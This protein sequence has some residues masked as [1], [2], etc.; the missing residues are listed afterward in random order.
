MIDDGEDRKLVYLSGT[1]CEDVNLIL[2]HGEIITELR[3]EVQFGSMM[4]Q[5]WVKVKKEICPMI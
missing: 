5:S 2:R 4:S 3:E 1:V